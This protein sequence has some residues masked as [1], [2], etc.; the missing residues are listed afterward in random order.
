M[1]WYR[2]SLLYAVCVHWFDGEDYRLRSLP[3]RLTMS[4]FYVDSGFL[5]VT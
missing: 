5:V 1:R 4:A 2:Y 3:A